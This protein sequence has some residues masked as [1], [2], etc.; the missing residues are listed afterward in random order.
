VF[1]ETFE[2][3]IKEELLSF[4]VPL[5]P[6]E[7]I[8]QNIFHKFKT[9]DNNKDQSNSFT[10]KAIQNFAFLLQEHFDYKNL[11]PQS[12]SIIEFVSKEIKKL[13]Q[14]LP[15][16]SDPTSTISISLLFSSSI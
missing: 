7:V 13:E 16:S 15:S 1:L 10:V 2:S 5:S 8:L 12:Q 4:L 14:F 6:I 3:P 11:Y 9:F